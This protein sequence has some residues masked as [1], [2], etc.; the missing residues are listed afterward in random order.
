ML[1]QSVW[2]RA[3]ALVLAR[4]KEF[5]RDR[6]ALFWNIAMP[7]LIVLGFAFGLSG[8]PQTLFKVGVYG[9]SLVDAT[10]GERPVLLDLDYVESIP[11]TDLTAAIAKVE[12]HRLDMLLDLTADPPRYWIND[13]SS[14][15][16][17]LARV[18]LGAP[19]AATHAPQAMPVSGKAVSYVDWL[20][21]GMLGMNMMFSCLY[22]VGYIVVRYRKNGVLRR[23]SAT[24]ISVLEFLLAQILSRLLVVMAVTLVVYLGIDLFVDFSMYGDYLLLATIFVVGAFCLIALGLIVSSRLRNEEV[25]DG[26][27]NVQ[28]WSMMFL[29][30]VW[31][32]LEGSPASIQRLADCLPLTH[33]VSAARTVMLDGA[34]WLAVA[35]QLAILLGMTVLFLA[36]AV[37]LF[38]WE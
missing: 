10:Q 4:N 23:L 9:D 17:L 5:Y 21:P 14:K 1:N 26:L 25:A 19:A 20:I 29:S 12:R 34:G 38:R 37:A 33:I 8:G 35:P 36:I 16:D 31:F 11:V 18:L 3:L 6:T 27:L 28:A 7:F 2:P 32:S 22:G 13:Q 30:G 15:G 24:P